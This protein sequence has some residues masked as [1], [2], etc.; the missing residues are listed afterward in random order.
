MI[1]KEQLPWKEHTKASAS[2]SVFLHDEQGRLLMVQDIEKY[3][4]KWSPIAG[5]VD[6]T[7]NEEPEMAAIRE[8]KEELDLDVRLDELI[9]VWHYYAPDDKA[10]IAYGMPTTQKD[11][12]HM[13]IGY[14]YRGTILG[15]SYTMQEDEIQNY[16]FFTP[17][18]FTY[19]LERN[20]IKTPQY[21][22]VGYELWKNGTRHPRSVV[23]TNSK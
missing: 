14:A 3:G 2:A 22:A 21:N 1:N 4:G 16:N 17:E 9:G 23:I 18:Q 19:M 8:A 13:H 20:E 7:N 12:A 15:G 10:N 11:K 5:F 6:V